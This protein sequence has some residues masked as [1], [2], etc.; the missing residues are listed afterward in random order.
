MIR[1]VYVTTPDDFPP[2]PD[3]IVAADGAEILSGIPPSLAD[4]IPPDTLGIYD[5]EL[6]DPVSDPAPT[7]DDIQAQITG[8]QAQLDALTSASDPS[9]DPS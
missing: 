4:V 8:L 7:V 3:T 9:Q 5:I 6:P 1:T 2:S